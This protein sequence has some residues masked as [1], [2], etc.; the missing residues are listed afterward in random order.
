MFVAG[1]EIFFGFVAGGMLLCIAI[2]LLTGAAH[3]FA[4]IFRGWCSIYDKLEKV[5]LF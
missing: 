1:I 5:K 3:V 2:L 4:A